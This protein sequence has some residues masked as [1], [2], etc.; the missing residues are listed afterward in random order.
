ME[1]VLIVSSFYASDE[2]EG[3][4]DRYGRSDEL[5]YEPK[6]QHLKSIKILK[7]Y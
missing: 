7:L 1:D 5:R 6:A 2:G 3:R 4:E